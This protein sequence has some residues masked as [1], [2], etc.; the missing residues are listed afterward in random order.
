[1]IRRSKVSACCPRRAKPPPSRALM[2]LGSPGSGA[3]GPHQASPFVAAGAGRPIDARGRPPDQAGVITQPIQPASCGVEAP[4]TA[5]S[6]HR[7][8]PGKPT[9]ERGRLA[10]SCRGRSARA[11]CRVAVQC[12]GVGCLGPGPGRPS[13]RRFSRSTAKPALFGSARAR[14]RH[15]GGLARSSQ[16]H[17]SQGTHRAQGSAAA[18]AGHAGPA[19]ALPAAIAIGRASLDRSGN[20]GRPDRYRAGSGDR[21]PPGRP[22]AGGWTRQTLQGTGGRCL[23]AA[24]LRQLD[25]SSSGLLVTSMIRPMAAGCFQGHPGRPR[26]TRRARNAVCSPAASG[27]LKRRAFALEAAPQTP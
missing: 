11:G 24:T 6:K 3:Q 21:P 13:P 27:P 12:G 10:R 20:I 8:R 18:R 26:A 25:W 19:A 17:A 22:R 16:P 7:G 5:L 1:V 15:P 14:R 9:P 23:R 4:R 2:P